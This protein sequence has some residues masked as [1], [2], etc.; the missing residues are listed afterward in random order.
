MRLLFA[1]LGTPGLLFPLIGIAERMRERG[2]EV[3]FVTDIRFE[4]FL[5]D[6]G[7]PRIPRGT[8]DG[9]SFEVSSWADPLSGALQVRH[10]E[11]AIT[12][13]AP[14]LLLCSNLALG[15]LLVGETHAI[16]VG[17][18]GPAAYM[19]P[20]ST[21]LIAGEAA[22]TDQE[23]R[24]V[25]RHDQMLLH[26][27]ALRAGFGMTAVHPFYKCSPLLGDRYF[28]QSTPELNPQF[29]ALPAAARYVGSCLL[30]TTKALPHTISVWM[31][32]QSNRGYPLIYAVFGRMFGR[33]SPLNVFLQ[34]VRGRD[35]AA[36]I[37]CDRYDGVIHAVPDN[38]LIVNGL[39]QEWIL[40]RVGLVI[41]SGHT[42]SVLGAIQHGRPLIIL[43]TGSLTDDLGEH[44][45]LYGNAKSCAASDV[46]I[47][48][49][50]A[51]VDEGLNSKVLLKKARDLQVAF[52]RYDGPTL[53]ADYLETM[54]GHER[55]TPSVSLTGKNQRGCVAEA[56]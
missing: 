28:I 27:N 25:A 40:P 11:F 45:E 36:V 16:P 35:V 34:W 33:H 30:E 29:V 53:V 51:L 13:F 17:V 38:A 6:H 55:R 37:S 2:H 48:L 54:R 42:T 10:L 31:D 19:W 20:A 18:L 1:S 52:R 56:T 26:Y 46:T 5:A 24:L 50:S 8:R 49:L 15:P 47:E 32:R 9:H 3:G 12:R 44:C 41:T 22:R 4:R 23:A 43:Y 39:A 21:H 7:F 14:D